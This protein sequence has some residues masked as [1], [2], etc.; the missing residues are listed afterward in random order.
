MQVA[1]RHCFFY[2]VS[3]SVKQGNW[4]VNGNVYISNSINYETDVTI[5][6]VAVE[7]DVTVAG[8]TTGGFVTDMTKGMLADGYTKAKLSG[9]NN[10]GFVYSIGFNKSS[11]EGGVMF[12]VYSACSVTG[13]SSYAV[14][15]SQI[16][17]CWKLIGFISQDAEDRSVGVIFDYYYLSRSNMKNPETP[18][19]FGSKNQGR[20]ESTLKSA[21]TWTFL[22]NVWETN[23]GS[24]PEIKNC[25]IVKEM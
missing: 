3:L 8:D 13:G 19:P 7:S 20:S 23:E 14:S 15:S 5:R 11:N 6:E 10:A 1:F 4:D 25:E 24:Y 12:D 21:S 9:S 18:A 16:H 17:N 22:S 2:S